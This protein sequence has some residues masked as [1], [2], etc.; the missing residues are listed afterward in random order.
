VEKVA[1]IT[2]GGPPP[3]SSECAGSG[4]AQ[5]AGRHN[6]ETDNQ[7]E[8]QKLLHSDEAYRPVALDQTV[9]RSRAPVSDEGWR[10]FDMARASI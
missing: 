7:H 5:P 6:T 4:V 1:T 10:N 8:D 9:S 3:S 2:A